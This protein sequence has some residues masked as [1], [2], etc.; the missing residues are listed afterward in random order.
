MMKRI[1]LDLGGANLIGATNG[2]SVSIREP[3]AIAYDRATNAIIAV[4]I[5]AERLLGSPTQDVALSRPFREGLLGNC[6]VTD[7]VV[8]ACLNHAGCIDGEVVL[9]VPCDIT[10]EQERILSETVEHAGAGSC[11]VVY[12]PLAAMAGTYSVP[13]RE[14]LICEIGATRTNI[15]LICRGRIYYMKTLHVAGENFDRAIAD[16]IARKKK[17]RISLRTAE[18]IKMAVGTVWKTDENKKVQYRGKNQAGKPVE[19]VISSEELFDCLEEP[20]STILEAIWIA[21]SKI[22]SDC[23][24][25]VFGL[26]IILCGGG[27]MLNGIDHMISGVTGVHAQRID[28]PVTAPALGLYRIA[29]AVTEPAVDDSVNISEQYI[30]SYSISR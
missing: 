18:E 1:A 28:S 3:A 29:E 25:Q 2:Q 20:L 5:A 12:S 15:M 9:T 6:T 13:K 11:R 27:C 26:G 17:I 24:K 19:S 10:N 8:S 14:C 30:K 4:G 16:Y 7:A 21:I 23:V 22:P